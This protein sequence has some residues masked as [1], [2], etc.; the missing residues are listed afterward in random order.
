MS[1]RQNERNAITSQSA[2]ELN[3][4]APLEFEVSHNKY[5]ALYDLAPVGYL[6]LNE[7]GF[8]K[9]VNQAGENLLGLRKNDLLKADF[10]HYVLPEFKTHF[11]QHMEA[12]LKDLVLQTIEI[13]LLKNNGSPYYAKLSTR[14]ILT[15]SQEQLLLVIITDIN[16]RKETEKQLHLKRQKI[17]LTDRIIAIEELAATIAQEINQH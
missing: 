16:A 1:L 17:A 12:A 8:I 14:A 10:S 5:A 15:K 4:T 2:P 9:D 11:I 7:N 6:I 3:S 13:K